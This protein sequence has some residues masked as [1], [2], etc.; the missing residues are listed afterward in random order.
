VKCSQ[1][2]RHP[3]L[4][5]FLL[6]L[7]GPARAQTLTFTPVTRPIV[8]ERLK[9]Y[10]GD[11]STREATLKRLFESAGC[12]GDNLTEQPVK[13]SKNPNVICTLPAEAAGVIVIGAHFD[14]VNV[15]Q[16]VVDNWSSASLL[17]SLFQSLRD[18]KRRHTFVFIGFTDEEKGLVGSAFYVKHL[19]KE[20][21]QSIHAMV[22]MD[23]LGLSF[24]K[25]WPSHSDPQLLKLLLAVADSV[26]SPI[27]GVNMDN[28]GS[29]DSESFRD[30]GIPS[31]TIHS[32]TRETWP[33]L[34]TNRD[35]IGQI[36]MDEYYQTYRLVAEYLAFLDTK[37][38]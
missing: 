38:N 1:W 21:K 25:T 22:N 5:L 12:A 17:P 6:T 24:T 35:N 14:R 18:G 32:V 34:H 10:G 31:L 3:C 7:L 37:L 11:N 2:G 4:P 16:G 27:A 23:T 36:H 26:H 19:S 28:V 33:I 15:G 20:Q 9:Q 8:E 13:S 29:T 30:A